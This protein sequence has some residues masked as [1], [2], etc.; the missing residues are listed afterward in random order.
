MALTHTHAE[1]QGQ[2]LGSKGI[3]EKDGR[4]D[5][6][7]DGGDCVTFRANAIRNYVSQRS[8]FY[9]KKA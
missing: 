6:W 9:D 7:T 1:V 8:T 3:V 5:G 4:T 2:S